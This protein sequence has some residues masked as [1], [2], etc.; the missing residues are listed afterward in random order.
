MRQAL[1]LSVHS[2][3]ECSNCCQ[4][5][6]V[7]DGRLATGIWRRDIAWQLADGKFAAQAVMED[8]WSLSGCLKNCA[9]C[10]SFQTSGR[11]IATAYAHRRAKSQ[12]RYFPAARECSAIV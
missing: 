3:C 9:L 6:E 4:I 10:R 8:L 7:A 11:G 5:C 1:R 2:A 12:R